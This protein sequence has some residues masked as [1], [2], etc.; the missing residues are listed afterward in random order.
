MQTAFTKKLD[1]NKLQLNLLKQYW[2][3]FSIWSGTIV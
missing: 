1:I 2:A 3:P